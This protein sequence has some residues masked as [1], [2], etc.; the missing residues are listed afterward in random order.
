MHRLDVTVKSKLAIYDFDG[1]ITSHDSFLSFISYSQKP[2]AFFIKSAILLPLV[3]LA[4]IGILNRSKIKQDVFRAFFANVS[5][6]DFSKLTTEFTNRVL[7][8]I[9]RIPALESIAWHKGRQHSIVILSASPDL[10][11]EGFCKEHGIQLIATKL[12][13]ID[14]V[15]SGQFSTPNCQGME[16]VRRLTTEIDLGQF[17]YIYAYGDTTGDKHF[18]QLAD[19][20][21][22]RPFRN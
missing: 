18:M 10:I 15:L 8:K 12:E 4:K 19:E 2:M 7:P 17:D 16:K 5:I 22:Y 13:T 6:E 11:L 9:L 3:A 1:T 20:S 21:H 14:G